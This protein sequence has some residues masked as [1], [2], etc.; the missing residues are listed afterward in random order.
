MTKNNRPPRRL[1]NK[2]RAP[3]LF[4]YCEPPRRTPATIARDETALGWGSITDRHTAWMRA[5]RR[6]PEIMEAIIALHGG[7]LVE[8]PFA[9]AG[10]ILG[11]LNAWLTSH[12]HKTTTF[13]PVYM[14]LAY[15][16]DWWYD[17]WRYTSLL[18]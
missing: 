3:G 12:G 7:D 15:P 14:R 10:E 11:N 1:P 4:D 2:P 9:M 6:R 13:K 8:H 17:D 5:K 16:D 18:K